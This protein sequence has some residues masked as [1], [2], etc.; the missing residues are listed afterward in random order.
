M[1]Q[2]TPRKNINRTYMKLDVWQRSI[3]L[4]ALVHHSLDQSKVGFKVRD[5]IEDSTLS[6]SSNIAEG[7]GRRTISEYLQ[8]LYV[9]KGS[10]AETL[11]RIAGFKAAGQLS[12]EQFEL[13]DVLHYEVEN[14][15]L[16]MIKSL[17]NKKDTGS[18]NDRIAEDLETFST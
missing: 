7:Y 13:I 14:K 1:T 5:Q 10:L 16:N 15:L 17:E 12:Q 11:S 6:I 3:D 2:Y 8:Y 9:A 18:W 4:Y